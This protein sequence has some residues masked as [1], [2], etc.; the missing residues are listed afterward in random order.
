MENESKRRNSMHLVFT[1]LFI[2]ILVI[3]LVFFFSIKN[4]EKT[5]TVTEIKGEKQKGWSD[6]Y[7]ADNGTWKML[8]PASYILK[9]QKFVSSD[10]ERD[11]YLVRKVSADGILRITRAEGRWK[12][13]EVLENGNVTAEGWID[14]HFIEKVEKLE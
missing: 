10:R 14:A 3:I 11:E 7:Y 9:E 12:H 4:D 8:D 5:T 1:I 2:I 6:F 13:V